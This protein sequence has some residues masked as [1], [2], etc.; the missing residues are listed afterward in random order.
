MCRLWLARLLWYRKSQAQALGRLAK[1][2]DV[3]L[4]LR[5]HVQI[6]RGPLLSSGS[7]A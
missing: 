1:K 5:S 6:S 3:D 7:Y 2:G 4:W